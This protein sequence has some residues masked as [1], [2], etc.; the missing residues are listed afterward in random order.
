MKR[1]FSV[2]LSLPSVFL[3]VSC[4]TVDY[5]AFDDPE[6]NLTRLEDSTRD[7]LFSDAVLIETFEDEKV[8]ESVMVVDPKSIQDG[9][10]KLTEEN[11]N[12]LYLGGG[13]N[14]VCPTC[15][16]D[17]LQKET[18]TV[19]DVLQR[20]GF[21]E[22]I[23]CF[24]LTSREK[25]F[26]F[27]SRIDQ[28]SLLFRTGADSKRLSVSSPDNEETIYH[29]NAGN[30]NRWTVLSLRIDGDVLLFSINGDTKAEIPYSFEQE[31]MM[32]FTSSIVRGATGYIDYIILK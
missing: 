32:N 24:K 5:T 29:D 23:V 8:A 28:T 3:F 18:Q 30:L 7:N 4:A 6:E 21:N 9:M 12:N 17:E 20:S 19:V 15:V 22:I 26:V 2:V 27:S 16:I 11:Q 31:K 10:I 25:D 14:Q 1:L 13:T